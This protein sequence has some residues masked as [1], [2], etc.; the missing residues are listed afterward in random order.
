VFTPLKVA[1]VD[2]NLSRKDE[3]NNI[4]S[5]AFDKIQVKN[6]S[7]FRTE[8]NNYMS[9]YCQESVKQAIEDA[10]LTGLYITNDL[11]NIFPEDRGSVVPLN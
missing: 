4:L 10:Q 11:A 2:K 8:Y 6:W 9:L 1:E 5:L 7:V 3:W